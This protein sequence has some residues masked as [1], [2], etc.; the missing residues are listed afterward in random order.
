MFR[1]VVA[2]AT[3]YHRHIRLR[4]GLVV[5]GHWALR[6]DLPIPA[7]RFPQRF[8]HRPDGGEVTAAL[9]LGNDDV[10]ADQLD[11]VAGSDEAALDQ[12]LVFDATPPACRHLG[13]NHA[14]SLATPLAPVNVSA[15]QPP[16]IVRCGVA[17]RRAELE[18]RRRELEGCRPGREGRR[19]EPD[20]SE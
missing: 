2:E 15:Y 8:L 18:G 10:A 1:R 6:S 11:P 9:R 13:G 16:T 19:P 5:D 12:L 20:A 3:R 17:H 14:R 4:L 7:E